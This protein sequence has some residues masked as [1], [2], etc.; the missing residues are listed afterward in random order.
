[1]LKNLIRNLRR[2]GRWLVDVFVRG[3]E[4]HAAASFPGTFARGGL[5]TPP[6]T[7]E[8]PDALQD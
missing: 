2:A 5:P 1:M 8:V 6:P 7:V 4:I 3:L